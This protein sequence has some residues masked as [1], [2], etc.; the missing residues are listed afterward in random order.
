MTVIT[1]ARQVGSGGQ[2]LATALS[3][4]LGLR[5]VDRIELRNEASKRG[6]SL[7]E[8]FVKFASEEAG[9]GLNHYL[10]YG[11]LEFDQ[12][13]RGGTPERHD[14]GFLS[15]LSAHS[16]EILLTLQVVIYDLASHDNVLFVGAGAQI[17]LAD[18]PQ[19]IRV[20]IIAPVETRIE[21]MVSAYSLS[22][23]DARA[24]VEA[25]DL[26]QV[27]YNRV[28]FGEDWLNPELW[29]IVVNSDTLSVDQIVDLVGS[30]VKSIPQIA[31]LKER[32]FHA[33]EINRAMLDASLGNCD[34][35]AQPTT[36]GI[37]LR[38]EVPNNDLRDQLMELASSLS[39]GTSV[40]DGLN[41]HA[42]R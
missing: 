15:E 31:D 19:V 18:I 7:P 25:G 24:A 1:L 11:E 27:D 40:S 6:L 23:D 34:A 8:S 13:L 22:N 42:F 20:K 28:I 21:R 2:V 5:T 36:E 29:D 4:R 26:E 38:G 32:L 41:V 30:L 10:S 9:S 16:R 3:Q 35:Y 39:P 37:L 14:T 12:A 33:S 17:L